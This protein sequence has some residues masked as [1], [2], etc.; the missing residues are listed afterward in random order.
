MMG[1]SWIGKIV[2]IHPALR[3]RRPQ[4]ATLHLETPIT[5][6]KTVL[7]FRRGALSI[8]SRSQFV[9][10][11]PIA[12]GSIPD[13]ESIDVLKASVFIAEMTEQR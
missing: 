3:G 5:A 11:V 2:S 1:Q 7:V 10:V 9:Y 13:V 4:G 12:D 6:T 8:L